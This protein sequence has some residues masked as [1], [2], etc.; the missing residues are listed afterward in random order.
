LTFPGGA[1]VGKAWISLMNRWFL[2]MPALFLLAWVLGLAA[3]TP[4]SNRPY[5]E[6]Y[7]EYR[8]VNRVAVFLQRWPVNR[9]LGIR[10]LKSNL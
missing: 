2:L 1:E 8:G 5:V 3:C 6:R 7:P 4:M 9:T 10:K